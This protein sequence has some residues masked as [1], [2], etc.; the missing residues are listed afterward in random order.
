MLRAG[1]LNEVQGDHEL[2][3]V[4][5]VYNQ[6]GEHPS[7]VAV[8][9]TGSSS[10]VR[11]VPTGSYDAT[12]GATSASTNVSSRQ[13]NS[14]QLN[15]LLANAASLESQRAQN[16]QFQSMSGAGKSGSHRASAKRKY[17]W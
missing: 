13:K 4:A 9:S 11:V 3:G 5:H 15:S 16:P 17:G 6:Q 14:N 10:E 1:K 2:Q 12:T 7:S 8:S